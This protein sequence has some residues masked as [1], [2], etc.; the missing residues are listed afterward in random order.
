MFLLQQPFTGKQSVGAQMKV[1]D[2]CGSL[3]EQ[4]KRQQR[5]GTQ[6]RMRYKIPEEEVIGAAWK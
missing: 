4:L 1:K 6:V 3:H 5:I 2:N